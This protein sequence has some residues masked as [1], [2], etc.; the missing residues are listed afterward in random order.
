M[1]AT[2]RQAFSLV[3][4][5][6][7]GCSA[8]LSRQT[9]YCAGGLVRNGRPQA[10]EIIP[11]RPPPCRTGHDP[12]ALRYYS[13]PERDRSA[14]GQASRSWCVPTA[15]RT[16][17][18]HSGMTRRSA[19]R[20]P[21]GLP[22][23]GMMCSRS[24]PG[25]PAIQDYGRLPDPRRP[26]VPGGDRHRAVGAGGP[27]TRSPRWASAR[28]TWPRWWSPTSTW[29]MRAGGRHRR[30]VPGGGDRGPRARRPAPGRPEPADG[31]RP[32]GLRRRAGPAV[33]RAG[34]D[35]GRAHPDA[36]RN[37]ADR[38]GRRPLAGQPLLARP[39]QAS[40]RA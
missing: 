8:T 40:R 4:H 37:A 19:D 16:V 35:P 3:I 32:D 2:W 26:A 29:I 9:R 11:G 20:R 21:R 27:A 17:W 18:N 38:P 14:S 28:P 31:Q 23:L 30:D 36:W 6:Q 13:E 7:F 33:R 34:A 10:T 1:S 22:I 5:S 39:R 24:I 15:T 12:T 25:W